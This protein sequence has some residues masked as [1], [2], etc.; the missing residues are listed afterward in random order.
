MLIETQLAEFYL[1]KHGGRY[2]GAS[3]ELPEPTQEALVSS[4]ERVLLTSIP[5]QNFV[6]ELG[7]IA[8]WDRPM[9]TGAYAVLYFALCVF[10]FV[11]RAVV[12]ASNVAA[13]GFMRMLK[14]PT[15]PVLHV[16]RSNGSLLPAN[17]S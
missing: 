14:E 11:T 4:F 1:Q 2:I 9:E 7:R 8:L 16:Y 15:D 3:S 13:P 12:S 5:V 17:Y 6:M 10:N